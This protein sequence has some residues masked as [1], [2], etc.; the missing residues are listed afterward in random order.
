[1]VDLWTSYVDGTVYNFKN[2][3]STLRLSD[4]LL[5]LWEDG[6]IAGPTPGAPRFLHF[7]GALPYIFSA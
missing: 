3:I 4:F 2:R 5:A 1:M 6:K 7:W